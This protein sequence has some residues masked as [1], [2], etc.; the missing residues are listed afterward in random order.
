M[1]ELELFRSNDNRCSHNDE[2]NDTTAPKLERKGSQGA[3][4]ILLKGQMRYIEDIKSIIFLCSPL[5]VLT[6]Y[7]H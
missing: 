4:S 1:F 2:T 5:Y 7:P 6:Q 3:R